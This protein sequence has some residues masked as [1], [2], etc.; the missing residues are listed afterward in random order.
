M[1]SVPK[2]PT[3]KVHSWSPLEERRGGGEGL[4]MGTGSLGEVIKHIP[5]LDS[6]DTGTEL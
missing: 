5:K 6:G 1:G 4:P 2:Q 3:E